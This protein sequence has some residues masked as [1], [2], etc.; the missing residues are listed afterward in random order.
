MNIIDS[1]VF[2][3]I[4]LYTSTAICII[5]FTKS[6]LF[7][8]IMYALL[9]IAAITMG[10]NVWVQKENSLKFKN[11]MF[12]LMY[13]M[14]VL[15]VARILNS[16]IGNIITSL[17]IILIFTIYIEKINPIFMKRQLIRSK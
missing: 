6:E 17:I 13:C 10:Y 2:H 16:Y 8:W 7:T 12:E 5:L 9:L 4:A 11:L 14:G 15:F 1:K 3:P